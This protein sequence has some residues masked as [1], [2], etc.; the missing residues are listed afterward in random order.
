[1]RNQKTWFIKKKAAK[2]QNCK[3]AR[4][5]A[6]ENISKAKNLSKKEKKIV[7][8]NGKIATKDISMY[9]I[10]LKKAT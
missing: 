8:E 7:T 6:H 3:S 1:M 10:F 5:N 9:Q 2:K 4:K